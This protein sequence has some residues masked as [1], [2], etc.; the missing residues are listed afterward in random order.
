MIAVSL[1]VNANSAQKPDVN[2][3]SSKTEL[4]DSVSGTR[5]DI[6]QLVD[7]LLKNG[8]DF[9]FKEHFAPVLGLPGPTPSKKAIVVAEDRK[10]EHGFDSFGR[11]CYLVYDK[12]TDADQGVKHPVCIY[13]RRHVVSGFDDD[14][15]YFR[16]NLDGKLEKIVM[17]RGKRD[18][19]GKAILGSGVPSDQDIESSEPK[20]EFAAEMTAMKKWLKVQQKLLLAKAPAPAASAAA[21][22]A[23]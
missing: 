17:I 7:F 16:V 14:D 20:K 4:K 22:A 18:I 6:S 9:L 19:N 1:H 11:A 21:A 2:Q 8:D 23:P 13:L 10:A 3:V 15:R 12:T 5:N